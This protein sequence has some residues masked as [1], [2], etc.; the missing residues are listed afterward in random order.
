MLL[1]LS[2]SLKER[3]SGHAKIKPFLLLLLLSLLI[4][5][6][7][8]IIMIII[9]IITITKFSNLIGSQLP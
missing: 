3:L 5:I 8:I 7:I 4:M 1:K 6:M 9:I 2:L